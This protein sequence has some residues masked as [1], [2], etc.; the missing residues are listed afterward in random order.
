[1]GAKPTL[2][3]D[4]IWFH[5]NKVLRD[6]SKR[7]KLTINYNCEWWKLLWEMTE[8]FCQNANGDYFVSIND[9]GGTLDI[10]ASLRGVQQILFD[11][12][13]EPDEVKAITRELDD[14][15]LETFWENH[16]LIS[17]YMRGCTEWMNVWCHKTVYSI[18]CDLATMLSPDQY[19]EFARPSIER[20]VSSLDYSMYHLHMYDTPGL[21]AQ[22]DIMLDI[23]KLD[24]IAFIPETPY[25]EGHGDAR[26]F[27]YYKRIQ[28]KGKK[29]M[30][31]SVD[32]MMVLRFLEELSP[33]GLHIHTNCASEEEAKALLNAAGKYIDE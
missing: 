10:A 11:I 4:S 7:P 28:E 23:E 27:P 32:P 33:K 13:D 12:M 14:I 1:V 19:A 17:R 22:L 5:G 9:L 3:G 26:W 2:G 18:Q 24:A 8:Y 30:M 20:Q 16:R 21:S 6:F 29:L 15:W 25:A 31:Y